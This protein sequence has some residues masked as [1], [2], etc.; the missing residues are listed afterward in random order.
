MTWQTMIS[1]GVIL[2]VGLIL[3]YAFDWVFFPSF[4]KSEREDL[5]R[6]GPKVHFFA[7]MI[8]LLIGGCIV[9]FVLFVG[10]AI[11]KGVSSL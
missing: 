10:E 3:A 5:A 11:L 6:T 9:L 2:F 7:W 8:A 1:C 4:R